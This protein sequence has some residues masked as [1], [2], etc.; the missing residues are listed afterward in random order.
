MSIRPFW[1]APRTAPNPP[2]GFSLLELIVTL[3]IISVISG[4]VAPMFGASIGTIQYRNARNDL[5]AVLQFTQELAIREGR[6]FR[7]YIDKRENA[8]WVEEL[9]Q[10]EGP[11][12]TFV[13]VKESFGQRQVLPDFID[14]TQI[15][16]RKDR[17][18]S[19]VFVGCYPNGAS[20]EA[21]ITVVDKRS[22][23]RSSRIEVAGV[24]GKVSVTRER[25]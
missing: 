22:R 10:K 9:A 25:R 4:M 15:R 18:S 8:Y 17:K 12:K 20:D 7:V 5:I 21:Q 3:A 13:P 1:R 14:L 16:A 23:G 19:D 11:L 2:H 6:E 24:L